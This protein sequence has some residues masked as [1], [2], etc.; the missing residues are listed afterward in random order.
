MN[1]RIAVLGWGSLI[2][3]PG[4]LK[5]SK[6]RFG[7]PVL[8]I[9]FSRI[10]RYGS[11]TLVKDVENGIYVNTFYATSKFKTLEKAINNLKKR[12][13]TI[14]DFIGFVNV[15]NKNFRITQSNDDI[16]KIFKGKNIFD[17]E[18][19]T[20]LPNTLYHILIG[21][22]DW[23]ILNEYDAVIWTELPNNFHEKTNIKWSFENLYNYLN[24]LD[25]NI[26][27]RSR[28]YIVN[29]PKYVLNALD[30]EQLVYALDNN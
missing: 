16:T 13:E 27:P 2:K 8:P 14:Q 30:G 23:C 11:V 3:R 6:F 21:I 26:K 7:G 15:Q 10:S 1:K 17:P 29:V 20:T 22:F 28:D 5:S 25:E 24:N 12:E 19:R 18:T 4:I 9:Q